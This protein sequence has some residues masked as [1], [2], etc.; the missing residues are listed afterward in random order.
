M[1]NIIKTLFLIGVVRRFSRFIYI[2]VQFDYYV[3][4]VNTL[5]NTPM[6]INNIQ[7][8]DS[9]GNMYLEAIYNGRRTFTVS[10]NKVTTLL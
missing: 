10:T 8:P 6:P 7:S 5:R 4:L 1:V 2:L 3:M 9:T